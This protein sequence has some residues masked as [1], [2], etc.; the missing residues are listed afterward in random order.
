[1]HGRYKYILNLGKYLYLIIYITIFLLRSIL[2]SKHRHRTL[3][4]LS[5]FIYSIVESSFK[6]Y[7]FSFWRYS[8][9]EGM[10]LLG[11]MTSAWPILP[12]FELLFHLV[13][14]YV[15]NIILSR[16]DILISTLESDGKK[17]TTVMQPAV[18]TL[19]T[20]IWILA[21]SLP[22]ELSI[23]TTWIIYP[24]SCRHLPSLNLFLQFLQNF[25]IRMQFVQIIV[26]KSEICF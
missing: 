8:Q 2:I 9:V 23:L 4:S 10:L 6:M 14:D 5:I 25:F 15:N 20:L 18:S 21:E 24:N 12:L 22:P 13:G 26:R 11:I 19:D 7:I 17:F 3:L 16:L 1:M